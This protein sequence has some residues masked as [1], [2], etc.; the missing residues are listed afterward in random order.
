M[1]EPVNWHYF[2]NSIFSCELLLSMQH[3]DAHP[4]ASTMSS[5][6][7]AAETEF[8]KLFDALLRSTLSHMATL[9]TFLPRK[10]FLFEACAAVLKND[11]KF[12][13]I[14]SQVLAVPGQMKNAFLSRLPDGKL[15]GFTQLLLF[16]V[17]KVQLE[18]FNCHSLGPVLINAGIAS[19]ADGKIID[20]ELLAFAG[21]RSPLFECL[22]GFPTRLKAPAMTTSHI[23]AYAKVFDFAMNHKE[24]FRQAVLKVLDR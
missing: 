23:D 7:T 14:A 1:P 17:K 4:D 12:R 19:L 3:M 18:L 11:S 15:G 10:S 2:V 20:P 9:E 6:A 24:D 13:V 8:Q 21:E 5:W 16:V 22:G